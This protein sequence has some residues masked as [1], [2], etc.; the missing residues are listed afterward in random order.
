VPDPTA[1]A[2]EVVVVGIGADGWDGLN[3]AARAALTGAELVLGGERQL[4]L[5]PAELAAERKAWPS[6][7]LAALPGLLAE[8]HRRRLV[9][10]ASG[11]PMFYGIGSTLVRLLGAGSLR[12][13]GQPSSVSLAAARLGWPVEEIEVASVLAR[14][15]AALHP[16]LQPG[17]RLLVLLGSAAD[18]AVVAVLL[19][20]RGLGPSRLTLLCQLGGPAERLVRSRAE[21]W[22]AGLDE[23]LAVLA[24]EVRPAPGAPLLPALPGLPDAA[25]DTDGQLTKAEVR[26]ITLAALAPVPGQLLWDVGAGSGSVCI[27]WMRSHPSCRA[28]AI[29]AR[30]DR[31]KR[32]AANARALGVPG[33]R[34]VAG[35]APQAL[36]GLPTPDA[37]FVGGGASRPGLLEACESALAPG[38]RLVV[39]GV[40]L[41]SETVLADWHRRLGG[42][43]V[44]IAVQRAEPVGGFTG[45]RPAMPV[46]QWSYTKSGSGATSGNEPGAAPDTLSDTASD[47]AGAQQ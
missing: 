19:A 35:H 27:E 30:A 46:T 39:N 36:V 21:D 14:P 1:S 24:I 38:G 17:R 33:L 43:L 20:E 3:A 4:A 22:P 47:I 25:F 16:L 42:R 29:E 10:L 45:W 6:P 32:I 8:R 11:D 13:I 2:P 23:P 15:V 12:V 18:A 41:E 44:R 34:L 28:V 26:A 9:V 40:T 5:L 31:G 37:V 7:M